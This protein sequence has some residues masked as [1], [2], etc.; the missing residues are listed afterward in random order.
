MKKFIKL[1][2]IKTDSKPVKEPKKAS[3]KEKKKDKKAGVSPAPKKP[4]R[5]TNAEL[6]ARAREKHAAEVTL[7]KE[8]LERQK[9]AAVSGSIATPEPA[10][11]EYD[12][13]NEKIYPE[14]KTD[15]SS[16]IKDP[17]W[18]PP[19]PIFI[20]GQRVEAEYCGITYKGTI[21]YDNIES[22]MVRV[23]WDDGSNQYAAKANLKLIV[24]KTFK[25]LFT[26]KKIKT[27][28]EEE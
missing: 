12:D 27:E 19:W 3:T 22:Q 14:Y 9:A 6:A 26:R 23:K 20:P 17:N 21:A 24:K 4:G 2:S 28:K 16:K 8:L 15:F 1:F 10:Q 11:I 7:R 13:N 18:I 5:P 25:K